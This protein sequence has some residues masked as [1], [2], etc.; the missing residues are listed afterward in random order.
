MKRMRRCTVLVLAAVLSSCTHLRSAPPPQGPPP[1]QNLP[2]EPA[3]GENAAPPEHP[4][5]AENPA[6][7]AEPSEANPPSPDGGMPEAPPCVP[8]ES[9]SK[10]KV[11]KSKPKPAPNDAV[12][13][14]RSAPAA[15]GNAPAG[16]SAQVGLMPMPVMSILGKR[17]RGPQ[18][19][20]L[21]RVVDVLAD[22]GGQVR[23]AI[24]DFGGFL[25]VGDR[26][27]AVDWPLLHFNAGGDNPAVVLNVGRDKL[28]AAPE[29]KDALHPQTL[30]EPAAAAHDKPQ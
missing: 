24:I 2:P 25:G 16:G 8:A 3:P 7:P 20:D 4:S 5:S 11:V 22:A 17:V 28:K 23:V 13:A 9:K 26:R 29:Y 18:G 27:I 30:M 12:P 6:S 15:A 1:V 21:G 14:T 19:E 10:P